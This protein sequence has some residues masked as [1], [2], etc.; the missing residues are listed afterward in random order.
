VE[1]VLAETGRGQLDELKQ[2][3]VVLAPLLARLVEPGDTLTLDRR[4]VIESRDVKQVELH[5]VAGT[6]RVYLEDA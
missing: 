5:E 2:T 1:R 3:Y 6:A 4:G